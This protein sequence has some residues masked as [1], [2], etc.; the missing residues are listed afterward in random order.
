MVRDNKGLFGKAVILISIIMSLVH[1]YLLGFNPID[2]WVFLHLHLVFGV[3]LTLFFYP[4][5]SRSPQDKQSFWDIAAAILAVM[6]AI[7]FIIEA[8]A[9][10][11][12]IIVAPTKLDLIFGVIIILL[13]LEITRRI[14]GLILPIVAILSLL[15][16]R[17]GNVLPGI[18]GHRD[19]SWPTIIS[20][21]TSTSAI[22][23]V[24]LYASAYYV[25]LLVLF[26]AFLYAAGAGPFLIDLATAI[27]GRQRGGPA[28]V[29][30]FSSALFGTISGNSVANVIATGSITIPMMK[31]TGY[32]SGFAAA[33]EAVASSGG[34]IMPP[35]MGSAA[36]IM[37]QLLGISYL[38]I[39]VSA[40]IPAILYFISLY[41]MIDLEA[42]K[43]GLRGL[44][45]EEIP[46]LRRLLR[47]Q[48]YLVTPILVLI[49]SLVVLRTSV[50]RSALW[51]I[52]S[53]LV[54]TAFRRESRMGL[55]K[56]VKA[57]C[58]GAKTSLTVIS[59]CAC[60]GLIIGVFFLTGIGFK[61]SEAILSLAGGST[62]LVL[63]MSAVSALILGMGMPTTASY[64]ICAAIV[65]PALIEIGITPLA[66][67]L[68]VF[69]FACLSAITPPVALAAYAGAGL[70]NANAMKVGFIAVKLGAVAYLIPFM[71]AYGPTLIGQGKL[72]G[73]LMAFATAIIG[74]I[75]LATS[76]QGWIRDRVI[77]LAERALLFGAA[78][79]MIKSDFIT[80]IVGLA[81]I[82]SVFVIGWISKHLKF[83]SLD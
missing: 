29:A 25:F 61:A 62:F 12:R 68:F 75:A 69:Y 32:K 27:T 2:P 55:S 52:A 33:V 4:A 60:A 11:Y 41:V 13:I 14:L 70:A 47:D 74:T 21:C 1:I 20:Q 45:K 63:V 22:F 34:Q 71:F 49:F 8:N 77:S 15:Y 36:F 78:L 44:Q 38:K 23:G 59:A 19:Y 48:G 24:S 80:D 10:S 6:A 37:A 46:S 30:I 54:V 42:G 53:V 50:I 72:S 28:K 66:A 43:L 7:Y 18:L 82:A 56:I 39:A 3:V 81:L 17:Y 64:L 35:I 79:C 58:D 40:L 16:A 67:H 5:T 9:I 31:K 65:A 57:L 26:S 73:I 76:L 51:A 83:R